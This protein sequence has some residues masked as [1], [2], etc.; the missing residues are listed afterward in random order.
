MA[1]VDE[2]TLLAMEWKLKYRLGKSHDGEKGILLSKS[3]GTGKEFIIFKFKYLNRRIAYANKMAN[4]FKTFFD[5]AI[6]YGKTPEMN[7]SVEIA[8]FD[9]LTKQFV[10][11]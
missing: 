3:A 11:S 6:I 2:T 5:N 1:I 10:F 8:R 4:G 9:K 7:D